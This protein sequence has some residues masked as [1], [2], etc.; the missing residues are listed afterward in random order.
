[1]PDVPVEA[2]VTEIPV[3]LD[4]VVIEFD[5]DGLPTVPA[6]LKVPDAIGIDT[7]C[8][9]PGSVTDAVCVCDTT[10]ESAEPPVASTA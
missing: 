1:M 3:V 7:V 8:V 2:F 10:I 9:W 5:P 4:A 6:P